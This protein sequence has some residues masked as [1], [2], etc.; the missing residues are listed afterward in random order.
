MRS[1]VILLLFAIFFLSGM[2]FG[3]DKNNRSD[4]GDLNEQIVEE[5]E[6]DEIETDN[7]D[8]SYEQASM[9]T[10]KEHTLQKVASLLEKAV[11]TFYEF[12]VH[13]MYQFAKLFTN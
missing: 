3:I 1:I 6:L 11:R 8:V 2:V 13:L 4:M 5:M 9:I 10:S 12:I 7:D